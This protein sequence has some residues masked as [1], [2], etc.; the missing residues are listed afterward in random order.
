MS[1]L[2]L[3]KVRAKRCV[4]KYCGGRLEL[5]RIAFSDYGEA[6]SELFCPHCGRIEFGTEPEIYAGATYFVD[7]FDFNHY[8]GLDDNEKTRR[9]NIAKVCDIMAW[10]DKNLGLLS[11]DGYKVPIHLDIEQIGQTV[12]FEDKDLEDIDV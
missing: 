5:R 8:P 6:R 7:H 3:L 10:N 9:M 12:V 4:C 2:N 1:R 11:E